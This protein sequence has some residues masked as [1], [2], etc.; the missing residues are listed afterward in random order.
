MMRDLELSPDPFCL[1]AIQ[2]S[3]FCTE[4]LNLPM[5]L[6]SCIQV[7]KQA[8]TNADLE[9]CFRLFSKFSKQ[10]SFN[11]STQISSDKEHSSDYTHQPVIKPE[12]ALNLL[13]DACINTGNVERAVSF[14]E[15]ILDGSIQ[16]F[17][18]PDEV[19]FNTLLK[20]CA[21]N[22]ML[23]KSYDLFQAMR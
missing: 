16:S 13:I 22:K 6:A 21:I 15:Q 2:Q 5:S 1:S 23:F 8:K 19:T 12:I 18:K 4:E 10:C 9:N 20:G 7:F 17:A 3:G 11:E 14:V